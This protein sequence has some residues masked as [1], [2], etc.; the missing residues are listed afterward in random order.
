ML[1]EKCLQCGKIIHMAE[2]CYCCGNESDFE[3]IN[4]E[5]KVNE[6][7]LSEYNLLSDL[8]AKGN[9]KS[10][11]EHSWKVLEWEPRCSSVFWYRLLASYQCKDVQE[12]I[13]KGFDCANPDFSNAL[14]LAEGIEQQAYLSLQEKM[15]SLANK[16]EKVVNIRAEEIRTKKELLEL[17]TR[18][19]MKFDGY[20]D[21]TFKLWRELEK[22]EQDICILAEKIS[23]L[24][25]EHKES[26]Q[27]AENAVSRF[28]NNTAK[29][30]RC[31]FGEFRKIQLQIC[32]VI[33]LSEKA[34]KQLECIKEK[35]PWILQYQERQDKKQVI[36]KEISEEIESF[37]RYCKSIKEVNEDIMRTEEQ[38]QEA[39]NAARKGDV[40]A[41]EKIYGEEVVMAAMIA[42]EM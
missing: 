22:I 19:E 26:L 37:E 39:I 35:H 7:V 23:V 16:L 5:V 12:L 13:S 10:V 30:Q 32:E 11:I 36:I 3:Q 33:Y 18:I 38:Y 14:R 1:V 27:K 20:R 34:K 6:S 24:E 28:R 41:V 25:H 21:K 17:P 2:S 42:S 31:T 29:I 4:L 9:Y 8:L 40:E 15:R